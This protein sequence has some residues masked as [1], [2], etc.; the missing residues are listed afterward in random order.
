MIINLFYIITLT[1]KLDI[2]KGMAFFFNKFSYYIRHSILINH[3]TFFN[4]L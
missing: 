4:I 1:D 2:N 3:Q